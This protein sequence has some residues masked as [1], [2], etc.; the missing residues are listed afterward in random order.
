MTYF[1]II[2]NELLVGFAV[3]FILSIFA[4]LTFRWHKSL[5]SDDNIGIQKI[6]QGDI[7]RIG[8]ITIFI[9]IVTQSYL[10]N[11]DLSE[12]INIILFSVSFVFISGFAEDI[13]KK[14]R[15]R[16]R[17]IAS[18]VSG[19]FLFIF[20]D[21]K[22]TETG[23]SFFDYILGYYFLCFLISV[24]AITTMSQAMNIIDGLNGLS[25][26]SGILMLIAIS[27]ISLSEEDF[28]IYQLSLCFL[29]SILGLFVINFPF[30]KIFLG[31]GGAYML[32]MFLAILVIL[33]P[34]RNSNISSLSS[35][36]IVSYPVY[37]TLRS[38]FRRVFSKDLYWFNPDDQHLHSI[39]FNWAI[40]KLLVKRFTAN[41]LSSLCIL[42]LPFLSSCLAI[43]YYD[44]VLMLFISLLIIIILFEIMIFIGRKLI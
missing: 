32:G 17:L 41:I 2:S 35:L 39:C 43:L 37:E 11:N 42:I 22:I 4:L 24:L 6:H 10:L 3:S 29:V 7:P 8:G 27:F 1:Q 9:S 19:T 34:E 44:N 30:G 38:F 25:I 5:S 15:P 20:L 12:N 40:K 36:L 28:F 33:M 21:I 18:F 23:F 26:G 31:D 16:W 14:I 13:T